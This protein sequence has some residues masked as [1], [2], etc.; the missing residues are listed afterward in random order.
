ME[1]RAGYIV[2]LLFLFSIRM[3][4][5]TNQEIKQKNEQLEEV[6]NQ[7]EELQD[8]IDKKTEL[9]KQTVETLQEIKKQEYLLNK[10]ITELK[11]EERHLSDR[12]SELGRKKKKLEKKIEGLKTFYSDYLV[13]AYKHGTTSK[14]KFLID[15]ESFNQALQRLKHLQAISQKSEETYTSLNQNQKELAQLVASL[16]TKVEQKKKLVQRKQAEVDRIEDKKESKEK[17]IADL[18][19][20][21]NKLAEEIEEK[22]KAEIEI[23]KLITKLIEEERKRLAE[24]R[25]KRLKNEDVDFTYEFNYDNFKNFSELKGKLTWPVK[26]GKVSRKFGENK[27]SQLNTVTLNYGVDIT[28]NP[29]TEVHAVAEG[30]ISAINWIPGFGSV[31][32]ISHKNNYKTVYGHINN[33]S[34]NVGD[35]VDTGYVL[36]TVDQSLEG[37]ILHF[38][39]WNQRNYQNPEVWLAEK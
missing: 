5:Q 22:R 35:K 32:I 2:V 17:L 12:I 28:T 9:E 11:K 26:S 8:K 30:Y 18:K 21:Q 31:I 19:S 7:I 16:N 29:E 4:S 23:K 39:I 34:V 33:I 15:A 24:A 38:E 10:L 6:K 37:S 3:F 25:T 27:N 20:D 1:L 13:W 14:L 36:G